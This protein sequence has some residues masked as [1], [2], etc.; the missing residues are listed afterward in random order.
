MCLSTYKFSHNKDHHQTY[1]HQ[2]KCILP[3]R[4]RIHVTLKCEHDCHDSF[5]FADVVHISLEK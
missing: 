2:P 3:N 4:M 5:Q 1:N